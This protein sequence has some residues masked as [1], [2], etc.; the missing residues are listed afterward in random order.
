MGKWSSGII[1]RCGASN[2]FLGVVIVVIAWRRRWVLVPIYA[3]M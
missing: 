1:P 3:S 2:R